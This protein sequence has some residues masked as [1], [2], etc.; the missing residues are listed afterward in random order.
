MLQPVVLLKNKT[1]PIFLKH[2]AE[3]FELIIPFKIATD[4]ENRTAKLDV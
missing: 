2:D 3:Q 1:I 4:H